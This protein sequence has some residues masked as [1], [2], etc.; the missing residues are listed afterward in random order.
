MTRSAG[1]GKSWIGPIM[2]AVQ[3]PFKSYANRTDPP[4]QVSIPN[5]WLTRVF[6]C[7]HKQMNNPLTLNNETYC[8]CMNCGA[9]RQFNMERARM[10]GPYYFAP[11]SPLYDSYPPGGVFAPAY[12]V[13]T[14]KRAP[15]TNPPSRSK[16]IGTL[17]A[18]FTHSIQR[19]AAL[20][21]P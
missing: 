7:W 5:R 12:G 9:R 10:T 16:L 2:R 19:M 20:R 1:G 18:F 17:S 15:I 6:G 14:R 13:Q 21:R 3:E 8:T 4:A 11:L